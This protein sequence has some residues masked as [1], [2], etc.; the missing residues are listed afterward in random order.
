MKISSTVFELLDGW[1]DRQME[2]AK[3]IGACLQFL[4]P[5]T[6]KENMKTLQRRIC[7]H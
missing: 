5:Y 1:M 7:V 3:L 6:L 4:V 2:M